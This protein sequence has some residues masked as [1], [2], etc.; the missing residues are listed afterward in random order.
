MENIVIATFNDSNAALQ[1]LK[2]LKQLDDAGKLSVRTADVVERRPDGTWKV[3]KEM[4]NPA[5]GAANGGGLTGALIGGMAGP[6]GMLLGSD[7]GIMAGAEVDRLDHD[8]RELV[9]KAIIRYVPPGKTALMGD[10]EEPVT[11]PLDAAMAN[12]GAH[13]RR[14]P[15]AVVEAELVVAAEATAAAEAGLLEAGRTLHRHMLKA[16]AGLT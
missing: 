3:L 12:L 7:V 5:L 6:L 13:T 1:G 8:G 2:E 16:K 11:E 15:R 10:V 9:H 4:H 14:W